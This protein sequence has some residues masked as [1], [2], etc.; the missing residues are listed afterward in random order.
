MKLV[1]HV[2]QRERWS[3]AVGNSINLKKA[4]ESAV[5]EIVLN[6]GAVTL[7]A[8]TQEDVLEQIKILRD[9]GIEI[10]VCRNALK[11]N[12]IPEENLP[13]GIEVVP[14]GIVELIERQNEGYAYVSP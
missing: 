2:S 9:L 4:D 5:G 14:A 13:E 11:G 12:E 6:A 3:V 1:L 7:F 8:D 10:K